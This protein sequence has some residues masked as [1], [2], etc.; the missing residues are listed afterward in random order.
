MFDNIDL[1]HNIFGK[2]KRIELLLTSIIRWLRNATI[3]TNTSYLFISSIVGAILG[4][5]FWIIAA[6]Y[7]DIG[8]IGVT[9]AFVSSSTLI[10]QIANLGLSAVIIRYLPIAGSADV[11]MSVSTSLIT[12]IL[13]ILC[14]FVFLM[15]PI[16][17]SIIHVKSSA[18]PIGG[19]L[20]I[21]MASATSVYSI[22]WSIFIARGESH[23]VLISNIGGAILRFLILIPMASFMGFG[24]IGTFVVG[25]VMIVVLGAGSGSWR[26]KQKYSPSQLA[27]VREMSL[28]GL[29]NY[30][31]GLLTQAPPMIYPLLIVTHVSPSAAGVFNYAWLVLAFLMALPP[32]ASNVILSHLISKPDRARRTVKISF[33]GTLSTM[34]IFSGV[35]YLT[36]LIIIPLILPKI[37]NDILAFL[38]I[39]LIGVVLFTF[40]RLMTMF[41]AW[42]NRLKELVTLNAIVASLAIGLPLLLIE[43]GGV[44]GLEYG[45]LLSLT[46][47]SIVGIVF[48]RTSSR[49]A[50]ND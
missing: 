24:L 44:M 19:T 32:A 50:L 28:Y 43:G 26:S 46:V 12:L 42:R 17:K 14:S 10:A 20:F 48:Y 25:T 40:V 4:T 5:I 34:A 9:S 23:L 29:T 35:I 22:Q 30:I 21:I 39:L 11:K 37:E 31:S 13:A 18:F 45:W 6:N 3:V 49:K 36:S 2:R 7:Y 8:S 15:L 47:G 1:Q 33:I 27:S 38:P 41:F 16:S